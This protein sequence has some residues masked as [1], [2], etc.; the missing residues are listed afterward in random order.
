MKK[1]RVLVADDHALMR[2][3]L[4]TL[5]KTDPVL[6]VVGEAEDGQQAIDKTA[7]AKPDIVVL[8]LMMPVISGAD[9]L[10]IIKQKRP[11]AKVVILTTFAISDVLS[12]ALEEGADGALL[13]STPNEELLDII[14]RV[15]DG[16]RYVSDEVKELIRSDPPLPPLSPRQRQILEAVAKDHRSGRLRP[17]QQGD[18]RQAQSQARQHQE[19][20]RHSL[21]QARSFFPR[22]SR[23]HRDPQAPTED[24][25]SRLRPRRISPDARGVTSAQPAAACR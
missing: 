23:R 7:E 3:G 14:H 15:A 17:V 18:R 12:R 16:E 25:I 13:K 1:I 4:A 6:T 5:F 8:D 21:Q 11:E 24:L 10:R 2:M 9:A 22:G 20:F 19:L